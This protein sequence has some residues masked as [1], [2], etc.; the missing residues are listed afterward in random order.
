MSEALIQRYYAAFNRGDSE[1]LLACLADDVAHEVNQGETRHGIEA[2]RAFAAHMARCYQ[3]ELVDIVV[4]T[5]PS[6]ERAAAEFIVRG[7]Y[8]ATDEGL[9][10]ARGQTY[11]LRAGTFFAIRDGRISRVTTCYNLQDWI[12]QVRGG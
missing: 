6:G 7:R 10:E 8:I 1:A 11:E 12:A 5:E 2:F 4:M 3:E 9:P